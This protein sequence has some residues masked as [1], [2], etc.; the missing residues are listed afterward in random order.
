MAPLRTKVPLSVIVNAPPL[1][2]DTLEK[3]AVTPDATS[4]VAATLPSIETPWA[5]LNVPVMANVEAPLNSRMPDGPKLLPDTERVPAATIVPPPYVFDPLKTAVPV[6]FLVMAPLEPL[7]IPAKVVVDVEVPKASTFDPKT[8]LLF[9]AP[10]RSP[11]VAVPALTPLISKTEV[12]EV[13]DT[14][15]LELIVPDPDNFNVPLLIAMPPVNVF[16][17]E[18]RTIVPLS[19]NVMPPE[20]LTMPLK[21]TVRP[22]AIS[23]VAGLLKI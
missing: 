11:I 20:P 15:L 2:P 3:V 1:T 6:P 12:D 14:G 5:A 13:K 7:I 19:V 18:V 21:V 22:E 4:T 16:D 9:D 17:A 8:T 23:K 10:D